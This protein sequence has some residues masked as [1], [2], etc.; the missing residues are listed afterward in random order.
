M[1]YIF[2]KVLWRSLVYHPWALEELERIHG[3]SETAAAHRFFSGLAVFSA[4]PHPLSTCTNLPFLEFLLLVS[5]S[6]YITPVCSPPC[7]ISAQ[8]LKSMTQCTVRWCKYQI[9]LLSPNSLTA[10][11]YSLAFWITLL[12]WLYLSGWLVPW[13]L[14]ENQRD[15]WLERGNCYQWHFH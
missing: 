1:L 5:T 15:A 13:M 6:Q 10:F 14:E 12:A 4:Q 8:Q 11:P 7:W 2:L 3:I 9:T